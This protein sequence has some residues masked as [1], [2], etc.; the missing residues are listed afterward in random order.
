MNSVRLRRTSAAAV[1][2]TAVLTLGGCGTGFSAQTNQQ[3]DA[4]VGSNERGRHVQV[5]NALFVDNGD[6]TATFSASVLNR[7]AQTH[8]LTGVEVTAENG[9]A[10]T[11]TFATPREL[12]TDT[13]YVP[14]TEGDI[15]LTGPIPAGGFVKITLNFD[16][17]APVTIN[18]PVVAR[19]PMYA[20]VAKKTVVPTPS[21][22][23]TEATP[24][25]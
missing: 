6:K 5:L 19:T 11:A 21:A 23:A 8:I 4:G 25:G 16:N 1:A 22:K 10:L 2:V 18:S 3:Y 7:D 20:S 15:I 17:A 9:A 14:G 24:A 13:P 12:K